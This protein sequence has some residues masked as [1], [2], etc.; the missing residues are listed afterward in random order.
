MATEII[1]LGIVGI[2]ILILVVSVMVWSVF[3]QNIVCE[4]TD[5]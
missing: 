3:T 1:I 2:V 5:F 4:D